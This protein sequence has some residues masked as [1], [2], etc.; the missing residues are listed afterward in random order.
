ME[1][2]ESASEL[3]PR[4]GHVRSEFFRRIVGLWPY[5]FVAISIVGWAY[6]FLSRNR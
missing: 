4:G 5:L 2:T 6:E 3:I 1:R